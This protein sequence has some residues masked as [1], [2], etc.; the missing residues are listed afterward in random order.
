MERALQL[1]AIAAASLALGILGTWVLAR[2]I[3]RQTRGLGP[4]GLGRLHSYYEALLHSVRAGLILVGKDG[5][6][7]LC[8]DDALV[9][10]G[11]REARPGSRVIDLD[12]DPELADLM[13]SGR[14]CDG[15]T[16][17]EDGRVLV[18]TQVPGP[19]GP[20]SPGLSPRP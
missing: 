8:N 20:A 7:V 14:D 18:V 12:L 4:L 13:S 11:A 6:V 3:H 9:L 2:R 16:L 10:V 19:V 1:I 5:T 15:E 17:V